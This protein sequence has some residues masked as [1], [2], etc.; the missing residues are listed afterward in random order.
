MP[1]FVGGATHNF[2]KSL[3]IMAGTGK[4]GCI[5][6]FRDALI[7]AGQHLSALCDTIMY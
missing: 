3:S 7:G 4:T 6:D 1:V 2:F 5:C